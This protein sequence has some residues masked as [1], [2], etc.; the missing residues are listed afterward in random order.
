[1]PTVSHAA[2][3]IASLPGAGNREAGR[4]DASRGQRLLAVYQCGSCHAIP[5]VAAA[6]GMVGPSLKAFGKR[7]YIAGQIPNRP[8]AL[9]RWI[10]DPRALVP[11]TRMPS[12]GASPR[13]AADMAAFLLTLE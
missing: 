1:M 8:E 3:V 5:D 10:A 13:D 6:R 7:S 12:M 4:A 2:D 11:D 9:A